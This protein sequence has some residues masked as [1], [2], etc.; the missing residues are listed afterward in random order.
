MG[1]QSS[2]GHEARTTFLPRATPDM[3]ITLFSFGYWGTG[4]A[5]VL[6]VEAIDA[7]ERERG[8]E[9]PLWVDIRL[10]RSVRAAGFRDEAFARLLGPRQVWLPDLGNLCIKE[11]R[12]G[13]EIKNPAAA[14]VLLDHALARP[15]R[16]TIFF[17]ACEHPEGCHRR[18]VSKLLLGA[19]RA[20]DVEATVVE[21]PGDEPRDIV[22]DVA[23]PVLRKLA[24]G[25][26]RTIPV[27]ASLSLGEAAA[28]PWGSRLVA[29][30]AGEEKTVL[31]G[32]ARCNSHGVHLPV[33]PTDGATTFAELD[34]AGRRYR[35]EYGYIPVS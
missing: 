23:Q 2:F 3:S 26:V 13:I 5:T 17:C 28:L 10:Q 11:H 27:P 32:P 6:Q 30:S 21:W 14:S 20:R 33:L 15:T 22:A 34:A 12:A 35:S 9:P 7:A 18:V 31:V 29:R 8:F 4:G 25:A 24:R 16:R 19:A 1:A